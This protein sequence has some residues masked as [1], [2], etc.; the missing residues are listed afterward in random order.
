MGAGPLFDVR[1]WAL[2]I[3]NYFLNLGPEN[4]NLPRKMNVYVTGCRDCIG[5]A[6]INDLGLVG[7]T[8][9]GPDGKFEQGFTLWVGGGLGANPIMAKQ[10]EAFLSFDR[11]LPALEAVVRLYMDLRR[12]RPGQAPNLNF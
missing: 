2:L 9:R 5:H 3:Q 7:A 4:L 11:V 8:R 10:L 12:A 1:P 6:R